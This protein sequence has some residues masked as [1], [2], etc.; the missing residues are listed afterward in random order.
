MKDNILWI[1]LHPIRTGGNTLIEY[2]R[3]QTPED[4]IALTSEIRYKLN[5]KKLNK[6][7]VRFMLGHATYYGI[8]K[9][10]PDKEPRY[11]VFLR[12]P[13]KR[14]ISYYN[15]KMQEVKDKIPFDIW[16]KNQMKNDLINFLDLKYKG[17]ES[18]RIHTP[19]IFMPFIR[20]LNYKTFSF[21]QN[22]ASHLLKIRGN[23]EKEKLENAKKLLDLC[24]FVGIV[25]NSKEDF[26][27]LFKEMGLKKEKLEDVNISKKILELNDELREKIYKE[28]PLDVE[29]YQY[30]LKL[31]KQQKSTKSYR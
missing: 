25:E 8:H 9:L 10:A 30:A 15:A 31:N 16:Y 14:V 2:I 3:K 4:E 19:K 6:D 13:A 21:L 7:K 1:F 20:K 17:S 24:W 29:L 5:S 12:D 18:S 27:F 22:I 23:R 26:E 28:N 11:F